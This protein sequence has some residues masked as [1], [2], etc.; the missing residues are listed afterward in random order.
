MAGTEPRIS[1]RGLA[2][3]KALST[4][5]NLVVRTCEL[6]R[7]GHNCVAI[8]AILNREGWRPPKRRD[9]SM[10]RWCGVS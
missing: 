9:I 5:P 3:L 2:R 1:S 6:H 8:A 4:Y 10:A 7:S